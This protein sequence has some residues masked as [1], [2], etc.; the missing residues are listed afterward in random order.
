MVEFSFHSL[1]LA[2]WSTPKSPLFVRTHRRDD[3]WKNST[4]HFFAQQ[5]GGMKHWSMMRTAK[6]IRLLTP[7]GEAVEI[8]T[9][10]LPGTQHYHSTYKPQFRLWPHCSPQRVNGCWETP[11]SL[12]SQPCTVFTHRMENCYKNHS[13]YCMWQETFLSLRHSCRDSFN[14]GA[15]LDCEICEN[16]P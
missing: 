4:L 2:S 1:P 8:K 13:T 16:R 12:L 3:T 14:F 11:Q 10:S 6:C 9:T 7:I 15:T 5:W